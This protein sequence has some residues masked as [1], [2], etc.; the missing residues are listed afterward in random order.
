M[1]EINT[2]GYG[3]ACTENYLTPGA[4][5]RRLANDFSGSTDCK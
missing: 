4:F 2:E 5:F 3:Y 1:Q